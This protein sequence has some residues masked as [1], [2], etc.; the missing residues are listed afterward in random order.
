MP[1]PFDQHDRSQKARTHC[2]L[3]LG[4]LPFLSLALSHTHRH[5]R[6]RIAHDL[7]LPLF[8]TI[9]VPLTAPRLLLTVTGVTYCY[10]PL[11]IVSDRCCLSLIC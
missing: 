7:S 3:R 4:F 8:L 1:I 5:T 6:R 10:W 2:T 11:V 9:S